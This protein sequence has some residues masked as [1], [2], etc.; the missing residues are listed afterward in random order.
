MP[1]ILAIFNIKFD[2][3]IVAPGGAYTVSKPSLALSAPQT[4]LITFLPSKVTSQTLSLSAFGC[5]SA[6]NILAILNSLSSP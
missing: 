4:T 3:G 5:F 2:L 6:F 1:L